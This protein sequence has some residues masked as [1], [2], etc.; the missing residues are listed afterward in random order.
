MRVLKNITRKTHTNTNIF[1]ATT[2][3]KNINKEDTES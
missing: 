1:W 3:K 2:L